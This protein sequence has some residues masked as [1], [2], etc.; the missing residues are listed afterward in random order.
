MENAKIIK[1]RINE[2]YEYTHKSLTF[3]EA[4]NGSLAALFIAIFAGILSIE[5]KN[6]CLEIILQISLVP[7]LIG[8]FIMCLSFFPHKWRN[9]NKDFISN[10]SMS[11]FN[12]ENITKM[13]LENAKKTLFSGIN[14]FELSLYEKQKFD[15][16]FYTAKAASRK[17]KLFRMGFWCFMAFVLIFAVYLGFVYF[18]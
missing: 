6:S 11:V 9:I 13:G 2:L 15:N 17:Y 8:V 4:K 5:A 10:E 18:F 12:C 14:E 3:V 7:L 16:V 1:E